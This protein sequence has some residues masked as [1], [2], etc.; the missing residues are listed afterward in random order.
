M[1]KLFARA[2]RSRVQAPPNSLLDSRARK[3]HRLKQ[4]LPFI[5]MLIIPILYFLLFRYWP[6]FGVLISFQKYRLG[7]PFLSFQ[8]EW[9]GLKW[10]RQFMGSP[11][12]GRWIKNTLILSLLNLAITFPLSIAMA[13]LLNEI[14]NKKVRKLTSTIALLP[15]FI[16][17]VVIVGILFNMFS[18]DDGL[19][20]QVIAFFG[21]KKIDFMGSSE[22]FRPLYIGS[23]AWQSVGFSSVVFTAAISGIDPTLYEAAAIDGSSRLKNIFRITLPCIL[24]TII[25]MFILKVGS[26][27]S[28]GY[29]KI[30]LMASEQIYDVADTLST[31]SY[32]VG[33]IDG[34]YS[35]S[36]AIGLFDSVINLIFLVVFNRISKKTTETALW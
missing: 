4:Q 11:F 35:L 5:I 10:F 12:F 32:R 7:S 28:V 30:I 27:M 1:N 22:W 13:L 29:E 18:I 3:I 24:P 31:Y 33:I 21:G 2:Q 19:V 16:S 36:A 23:G 25:I 26:I 8:S 15:H 14:R 9:V 20:N 17:T 34:R 6:M